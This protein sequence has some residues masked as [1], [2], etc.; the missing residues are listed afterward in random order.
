MTEPTIEQNTRPVT[1]LPVDA[2]RSLPVLKI[3]L[4]DLHQPWGTMVVVYGS[5]PF[6]TLAI[7]ESITLRPFIESNLAITAHVE[8]LDH[9]AR[10]FVGHV[11]EISLASHID[12]GEI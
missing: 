9:R 8:A 2:E 7:G 3:D 1:D 11:D 10:M 5:D 4:I 12:T 6:W